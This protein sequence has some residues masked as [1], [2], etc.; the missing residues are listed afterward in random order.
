MALTS[1][2]TEGCGRSVI[3]VKGTVGGSDLSWQG[4]GGTTQ[5]PTWFHASLAAL[6]HSTVLPADVRVGGEAPGSVAQASGVPAE[7]L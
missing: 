3:V 7:I 5:F 1:V 6:G 2:L 4:S